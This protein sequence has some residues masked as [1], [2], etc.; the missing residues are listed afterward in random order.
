ML[1]AREELKRLMK[2]KFMAAGLH[3]G[4]ADEMAEVLT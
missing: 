1:V 3:E 2:G 4:H